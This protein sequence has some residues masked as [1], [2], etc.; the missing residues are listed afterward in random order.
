M[1]KDKIASTPTCEISEIFLKFTHV[2]WTIG[3]KL[4]KFNFF[5]LNVISF[6]WF[7]LYIYLCLKLL[8]SNHDLCIFSYRTFINNLIT[9]KLSASA[10]SESK[11]FNVLLI[12]S[13]AKYRMLNNRMFFSYAPCSSVSINKVVSSKKKNEIGT[14]KTFIEFVNKKIKTFY[15]TLNK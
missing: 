1:R 8:N 15:C 3:C 7:V 2:L 9:H 13:T 12:Q 10:R 5:I 4:Y 6:K 11:Y 14:H